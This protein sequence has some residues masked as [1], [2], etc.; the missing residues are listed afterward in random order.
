M[1]PTLC[2]PDRRLLACLVCTIL[3]GVSVVSTTQNRIAPSYTVSVGTAMQI[4][5]PPV[6]IRIVLAV[7]EM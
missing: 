4:W 5:W 7:L 6:G 3:L 2:C 1:Q